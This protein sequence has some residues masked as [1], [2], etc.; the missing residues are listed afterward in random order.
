[1]SHSTIQNSVSSQAGF[2]LHMNQYGKERLPFRLI[3]ANGVVQRF[4]H[5]GAEPKAAYDVLDASGGYA[6]ACM[7]SNHPMILETLSEAVKRGYSTDE[8]EDITRQTL[9]EFL[10][11]PD[12]L[13]IDH[14]FYGD[15]HA[16][17]RNSGSEGMELAIRLLAE[18]RFDYRHQRLSD[19]YKERNII[20]AFE[21]AWH[22]WT[23][24]L[25]P[26]LNRRHYRVGLM[27][28]A[29]SAAFGLTVHHIPFGDRP[30]L[31]N[32]FGKYGDKLLGVVVE[33]IQGDAG[34]IC[35]P[36][37]YLRELAQ[38]TNKAGAYLIA[39]EV[40]TFAKTG[41]F[42]AMR[43]ELGPVPTDITVIGKNLGMGIISA[44][45]V[46]ARRELTVRPTGAVCTSDLRPL[47][48]HVMLS[49]LKFLNSMG[50]ISAAKPKG[51]RLRELLHK[52]LKVPFPELYREVRG[53]GLLNGVE[54]TPEAA[55]YANRLRIEMIKAGA[56]VELMAGAGKRSGGLR[57]LYPTLRFAPP[58]II[59]EQ[60]IRDLV[61]RAVA[62]T[63]GFIGEKND[64]H[65]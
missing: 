32:F 18:A 58:L 15:F 62:G 49:G 19:K 7:G 16:A 45:L 33:P 61:H 38:R 10:L 56:Y 42:F 28:S 50:L 25:I 63:L 34:I 23:A 60:Q 43:D 57:Y 35:P 24:G 40:L 12:G 27:P 6:S 39:D 13:W 17:G 55:P 47:A 31:D 4:E 37:G 9:L 65:S 11:G 22:G 53:E 51:E 44:S 29:E 54:L 21:G 30:S 2:S 41:Q 46:I 5:I 1:M 20:L 8:V 48:C 14:F 59:S 26:L 36:Q 3:E 64:N 52:E